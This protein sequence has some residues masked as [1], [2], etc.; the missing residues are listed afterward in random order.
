M[1]FCAWISRNFG[2][3]LDWYREVETRRHWFITNFPGPSSCHLPLC[4][5]LEQTLRNHSSTILLWMFAFSW[6]STKHDYVTIC[7]HV[8]YAWCAQCCRCHTYSVIGLSVWGQL[9]GLLCKNGWSDCKPAGV[10]E[11]FSIR[12]SRFLYRK[13][14]YRGHVVG[15]SHTAHYRYSYRCLTSLNITQMISWAAFR[16]WTPMSVAAEQKGGQCWG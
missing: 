5:F 9:W 12:F 6:H 4:L 16:V 13:G 14:H 3:D 1:P 7:I 15:N 2:K 11:P 10:Q 8:M